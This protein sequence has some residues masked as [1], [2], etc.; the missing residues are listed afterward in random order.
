[1]YPSVKVELL[2]HP[3][4]RMVAMLFTG[5]VVNIMEILAIRSLVL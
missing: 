2:L 3:L 4:V 5:T 1:M